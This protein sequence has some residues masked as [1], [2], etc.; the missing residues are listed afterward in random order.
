MGDAVT[1]FFFLL[2]SLFFFFLFLEER[3]HTHTRPPEEPS[4]LEKGVIQVAF[5][6]SRPLCVSRTLPGQR[7]HVAH[8]VCRKHSPLQDP[9]VPSF[10]FVFFLF[11]SFLPFRL[12]LR[13]RRTDRGRERERESE[14][15]S[16]RFSTSRRCLICRDILL[17]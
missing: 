6:S 7:E 14:F 10:F 16:S 1:L 9:L 17:P 12:S 11:F 4:P 3:A 13:N 2:S 15:H 8:I 5:L